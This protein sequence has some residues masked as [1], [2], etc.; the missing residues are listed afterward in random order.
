MIENFREVLNSVMLPSRW[1][2]Y[3]QPNRRTFPENETLR[4]G[5]K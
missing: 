4:L 2:D 1:G 5:G 3:E